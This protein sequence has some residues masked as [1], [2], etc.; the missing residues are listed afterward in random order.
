MGKACML[1]I[2]SLLD[3]FVALHNRYVPTMLASRR[4]KPPVDNR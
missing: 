3:L 2:D 1:R 4:D